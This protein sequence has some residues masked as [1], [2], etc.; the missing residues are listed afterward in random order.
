[1]QNVFD[2]LE[3]RGDLPFARD[4]FNEVDNLIISVLA[5]LNFE[6]IV[7]RDIEGESISLGVAADLYMK[8]LEQRIPK[9]INNPFFRDMPK[10][11][12]KAAL[13]N[14]Y[15]NIEL[16]GYVDQIDYEKSNQFS[17]MVFSINPS[18]HFI[19]F[20]GTDDTLA[21]W[22]EDF[23][24]SFRDEVKAQ[25]DAVSYVKG[26]LTG[27]QGEFYLGGHSKGGNLAV[28]G[29]AAMPDD[30]QERIIGVYNNDGPGFLAHVI[31][32][33][34]YQRIIDRIHTFIP[35]SSVVGMLLEHGEEYITVNSNGMGFM[36]HNAFFWEVK[37]S[38]FAY[39]KG[40]T[41]GSKNLN[42]TVRLWLNQLSMGEREEFVDALFDILQATGAMTVSDLSRRNLS[43]ANDM[44]KS[45]KTLDPLAQ[46]NLKKVIQIFFNKTQKVWISSLEKDVASLLGHGSHKKKSGN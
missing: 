14:R 16:S 1:M 10:L 40:L 42:K 26:I 39:E 19:A 3:W 21:G 18:E 27:Y 43:L 22:K 8:S 38:H 2:Y 46:A 15:K 36:Q 32:R 34:G 13:T 25:R 29:A 35:K 7:P 37:G 11:L 17:A 33:E 12:L 6:G 20:R 30:L 45:Y 31:E 9:N 28:Y 23:Q 5:Y 41:K 4:Q 44:I 24:M